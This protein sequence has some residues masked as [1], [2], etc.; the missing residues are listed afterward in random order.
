MTVPS[1]GR[2][3]PISGLAIATLASSGLAFAAAMGGTTLPAHA[4]GVGDAVTHPPLAPTR[5]VQ[6][7]Y[8]VQP[9]GAPAPKTVQAWFTSNGGMMRIDSPEGEGSTILDRAARQVTIVLN[10]QKVYTRLDA[11][12]GIRNPFLLDL[13]MQFTRK[14]AAQVASVPCTEWGVVSGRGSAT[15]CVT[16]DGVILREDGVDGDGMKGRLEATKVVYG[17]IASAIFQPPAD[18]QQVTRHRVAPSRAIGGGQVVT[19]GMAHS[20]E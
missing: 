5:D 6:V 2:R 11:Q 1:T 17:P 8:S 16:D 13:S 15:A 14:G 7:E 3:R 18:Y 4:Q 12:Y 10:K 19:G 9:E 20:G